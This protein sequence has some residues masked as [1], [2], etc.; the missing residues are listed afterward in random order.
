M[1]FL[2]KTLKYL[3]ILLIVVIAFLV[4]VIL[5]IDPIAKYAIQ[6]YDKQYLGR[7]ISLNNI[8]INVFTASLEIN[9]FKLYEKDGKTPFVSWSKFYTQT[10][11]VPLFK[12]ELNIYPLE[13]NNLYVNILSKSG[14]LNFDDILKKIAELTK[15][16]GTKKV[17]KQTSSEDEFKVLIENVKISNSLFSY[18]D[19]DRNVRFWLSKYT[20]IVPKFATYKNDIALTLLSKINE[21]GKLALNLKYDL[22]KQFYD[23]A[24]DLKHFPMDQLNPYV[25]DFL[26]FNKL[27]SYLS[28]KSFVKGNTKTASDFVISGDLGVNDFVFID[29]YDQKITSWNELKIKIDTLN[30][31]KNIYKIGAITLSDPYFLFEMYPNGNS[32]NRLYQQLDTAVVVKGNDTATVVTPVTSNSSSNV[33]VYIYDY[34]KQISKDLILNTYSANKFEI[35]NANV[36]YNDFLVGEKMSIETKNLNIATSRISSSNDSVSARLSSLLNDVGQLAVDFTADAKNFKD[37]IVNININKFPLTTFNAYSKYY[38]GFPFKK[39]N[40]NIN[41][42]IKILDNKL[43][44]STKFLLEKS[45]VGKKHKELRQYNVPLKLL[46]A[47]LRDKKGN[48]DI[49]LPVDGNLDDPNYKIKPIVLKLV[50]N[51]MVKTISAPVNLIGGMLRKKDN[52]EIEIESA[53]LET[54]LTKKQQ[55]SFKQINGLL[56]DKQELMCEIELNTDTVKEKEL[57]TIREIKKCY[58]KDIL[59][60][61]SASFDRNMDKKIKLT[62]SLF[63]KYIDDKIAGRVKSETS[64]IDKSLV[65]IGKDKINAFYTSIKNSKVNALNSFINQELSEVKDRVKVVNIVIDKNLLDPVYIITLDGVD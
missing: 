59:Q 7:E 16:D 60:L 32:I 45:K 9:D 53:Y 30:I 61:D 38:T 17:E 49:D 12:N 8:H 65:I 4:L 51:L 14:K 39:G 54:D 19:G 11:Y 46:L 57:L 35:T 41:S 48:V 6:K 47:I 33:F 24:I 2:K 55:S 1:K 42:S 15:D 56:K 25:K 37:M 28:V 63:V 21:E 26:R 3:S 29:A 52:S 23:V 64:I 31:A 5:F 13:I 58:A 40:L 34:F 44:S 22:K 50:K 10:D 62:D 36:V 27:H 43:N 18:K 20:L